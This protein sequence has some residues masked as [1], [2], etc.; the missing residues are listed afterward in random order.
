MN[1]ASIAG[2]VMLLAACAGMWIDSQAFFAI[3]LAAWWWC[4]GLILGSLVNAWV[5]RITGGR[6]GLAIVP[7]VRHLSARLPWLLALFVPIAFGLAQIYPWA[8]DPSGAWAN[9]FGRPA[10]PRLWMSPAW[11][12]CRLLVY[13]IAWWWTSRGS[14]PASTARACISLAMHAALT[15]LAAVDLLGSL[16]PQWFSTGFGMVAIT[17]QALGGTALCTFVLAAVAQRRR[18]VDGDAAVPWRDLGNLLLMWTLLWAYA[19]FMQ[20]L[21][22]WSENLPREISW[23]L[24][25]LHTAWREAALAIV[26][27]QFA[28]PALML[29]QRRIKD[30]PRRLAWAAALALAA[31]ALVALWMVLPSVAPHDLNAWWLAPLVFIGMGLLLFAA[32]PAALC[33]RDDLPAFA[34]PRHA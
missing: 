18:S 10:F 1:R 22:I 32:V 29:L 4:L 23:Y 6:W 30:H 34:E 27:L 3:W 5:H 21:I 28:L 15:T 16:V 17:S 31:N 24:P 8:A 7:V 20:Y 14:P 25:R 9:G 2:G 19:A 11:V 13:A 33:A 12:E 26:I